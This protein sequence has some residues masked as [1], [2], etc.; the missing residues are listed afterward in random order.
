MNEKRKLISLIIWWCE[1]TKIRKDKRWK[2]SYIRAIEVTNTDPKLIKIFIDFLRFD[3]GIE[4]IK[5][6]AQVQIHK[7]D[8]QS[9]IEKFWS[10]VSGIPISQFNKTIVRKKGNKIGKNKGTF[11]VRTYDKIKFEE[12]KKLLEAELK[13][14]DGE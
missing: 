6:K 1:G 13:E 4:N 10:I 3:L 9:E 5:L 14:Y 12:M 2:N 11:K 7:G 8:N